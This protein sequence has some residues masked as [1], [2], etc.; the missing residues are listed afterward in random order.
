MW[1]VITHPSFN[2]NSGLTKLVT[3][4]SLWYYTSFLLDWSDNWS[5][6]RFYRGT[7]ITLDSNEV[8]FIVD[9]CDYW[10]FV[11]FLWQ[12]EGEK[13]PGPRKLYFV[14]LLACLRDECH[15]GICV[16]DYNRCFN[17]DLNIEISQ[18]LTCRDQINP[19]QNRKYHGCWCPGPSN[20]ILTM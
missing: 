5:K 14:I 12:A 19:V 18:P 11:H 10:G 1:G 6:N 7:E 4:L 2:I 3:E 9:L 16:I 17:M 13:V 15:H 8:Q 20:V